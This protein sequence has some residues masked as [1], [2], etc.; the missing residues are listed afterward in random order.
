MS[1]EKKH[2]LANVPAKTELR[3]LAA[4]IKARWI[5]EQAHQQMKEELGLDHFEGR[6]WQGWER[7]TCLLLHPFLPSRVEMDPLGACLSNRN[8]ETKESK[9]PCAG[10]Y[11]ARMV[12]GRFRLFQNS[13]VQLITRTGS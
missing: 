3:T 4:T 10:N 5:C 8:G 1:G 11:L 7:R 13:R 12:L 6:S 2:H 9:L